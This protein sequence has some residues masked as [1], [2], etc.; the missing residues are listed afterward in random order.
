[1]IDLDTREDLTE[2]AKSSLRKELLD[3]LAEELNDVAVTEQ[4]AKLE[5]RSMTMVL[6]PTRRT[7]ASVE[8]G[9]TEQ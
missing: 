8:P 4:S 2:T 9:E 1:V 5:G 7:R 6:A 3:R